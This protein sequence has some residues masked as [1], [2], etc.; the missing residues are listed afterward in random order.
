MRVLSMVRHH[1]LHTFFP[2]ERLGLFFLTGYRF[3]IRDYQVRT[4]VTILDVTCPN[5]YP[6]WCKSVTDN[7]SYFENITQVK[8]LEIFDQ[9]AHCPQKR[10]SSDWSPNITHARW[11][12]QS[13]FEILTLTE[14]DERSG[15]IKAIQKSLISLSGDRSTNQKRV[16]ALGVLENLKMRMK[17]NHISPASCHSFHREISIGKMLSYEI[18]PGSRTHTNLFIQS[19][20]LIGLSE[21][22]FPSIPPLRLSSWSKLEKKLSGQVHFILCERSI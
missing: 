1:L 13:N 22:M 6:L 3:R 19:E 2:I 9:K 18:L 10:V 8:N 11:S 15:L 12:P 16:E 14:K 7:H 5:E 17:K 20:R 21:A 4:F